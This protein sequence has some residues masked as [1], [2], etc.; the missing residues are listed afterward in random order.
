MV[1]IKYLVAIVIIITIFKI[2]FGLAAWLM[3]S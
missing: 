3:E 2:F 1:D